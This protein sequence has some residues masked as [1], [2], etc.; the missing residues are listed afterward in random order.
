MRTQI[1]PMDSRRG[2]LRF[3]LCLL[4]IVWLP[5]QA[6]EPA[7]PLDLEQFV[8]LATKNDH[9]FERILL[10]QLP[11]KYRRSAILP[12]QDI[13]FS[14]K[15]QYLVALDSGHD[16]GQTG[17]SLN[18]LFVN[19]ATELSVDYEKPAP[20]SQDRASL[21]FMISQPIAKNAFG[22]SFQL[23]DEII[24]IEN[25]IIRHQI[26]EAYE[27]YFAAT[28]VA[29]YD[30]YSSFENLKVG[31]L[32]LKSGERLL[33]NILDRRR[34]NIALPI[35]VNKMKLS[36][37][38]KKESLVLLEETYAKNTNII[39]KAIAQREPAVFIP[40][41]PKPPVVG[42]D[43]DQ[44]YSQFVE[45]S[46][47]Y[48]I[49]D[50]LEKQDGLEVK[51][52]ADELLPSTNLLLGYELQ[53][54]QWGDRSR[55]DSLFAGIEF[56]L[57][58]GR[59]VAIAKHEISRIQY[60]KTQLSNSNKYQELRVILKNLYLQIQREQ[61]LI[62]ISQEKIKLADAILKD[63]TENY[64]YGKVSLND[65]ITAVN[66]ADENRFS[67]T[68]HSVQL[69]KLLV[70]WQRLTDRLVDKS[71]VGEVGIEH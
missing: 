15:Q 63:E 28:I 64:S 25:D 34:Q 35:D 68:A 23:L 33:Q 5:L 18:K 50:L 14:I 31:R 2:L 6:N 29:Y 48:K 1:K 24:G 17:V 44:A 62:R 45:T 57:P 66:T 59:S 7:K 4:S 54:E 12:D 11:L 56:S 53:G 61:K 9:E 26:I 49:L 32:A 40:Q 52:N 30:W 43:F 47:T 37:I 3:G 20:G 10:D 69:Y 36:L 67:N 8:Q 71:L 60:Q 19:S 58:I 13:L 42:D 16:Q 46:R 70:E 55:Q 27:D 51:R 39:L 41:K 65:Y 38:N 21:Q 22:K